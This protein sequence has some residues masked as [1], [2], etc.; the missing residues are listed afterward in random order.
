MTYKLT[1]EINN[2]QKHVIF[3]QIGIFMSYGSFRN[4]IAEFLKVVPQI[5]WIKGKSRSD[6]F[7]DITSGLLKLC[8]DIDVD[9]DQFEDKYIIDS[10][11]DYLE[12]A[13]QLTDEQSIAQKRPFIRDKKWHFY[14]RDL[15]QWLELH[16]TQ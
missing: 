3:P 12:N 7:E 9:R 13:S 2:E 4:T 5:K 16:K 6:V 15:R 1:I 14:S 11:D 8:E 10:I